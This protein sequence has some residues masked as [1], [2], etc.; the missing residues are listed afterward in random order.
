MDF[1]TCTRRD[2]DKVIETI[3]VV[4]LASLYRMKRE[5]NKITLK[6]SEERIISIFDELAL[7]CDSSFKRLVDILSVYRPDM[8]FETVLS[9]ILDDMFNDKIYSWGRIAVA[10]TFAYYLAL[11]VIER[12]SKSV[13]TIEQLSETAGIVI[14]LRVAPWIV[15]VGGWDAFIA[16]YTPKTDWR[17]LQYA[18]T[19]IISV[20]VVIIAITHICR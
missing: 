18:A 6:R 15:S 12:D 14:G 7:G 4:T 9:T 2:Y 1:R 13:V 10:M 3:R 20:T 8:G 11:T 16:A 17:V 19:I 5:K